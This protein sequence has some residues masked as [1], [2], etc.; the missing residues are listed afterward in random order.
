MLMYSDASFNNLGDGHSQGSYIIFLSDNHHLYPIAWK[1]NKLK[2]VAR[3]TLA[4]ETLA[5]TDGCDAAYT[6]LKMAQETNLVKEDCY[7][8]LHR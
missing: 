4:T 2:R 1:S 3:S 6:L 8:N 5:F 7:L